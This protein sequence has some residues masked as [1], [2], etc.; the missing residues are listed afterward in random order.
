MRT[1]KY[2]QNKDLEKFDLFD[3]P[4]RI[5]FIF[6]LF[7]FLIAAIFAS[8]MSIIIMPF[9]SYPLFVN[10]FWH[11]FGAIL[12]IIFLLWIFSWIF[13]PRFYI[14]ALNKPIFF[15]RNEAEEILR[16]RFARGEISKKEFEDMMKKL[17]ETKL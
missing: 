15:K 9:G 1:R 4:F 7:V 6:L 2:Y 3:I 8:I 12:G 17:R 13:R 16:I 11:V 14:K 5:V 10:P